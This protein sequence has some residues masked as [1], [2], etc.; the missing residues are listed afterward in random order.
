MMGSSADKARRCRNGFVHGQIMKYHRS[1]IAEANVVIG[2]A[3]KEESG[4]W[5]GAG[6]AQCRSR[7]NMP[8]K[9]PHRP[10]VCGQPLESSHGPQINV[11]MDPAVTT[12]TPRRAT[13]QGATLRRRQ[14]MA[15]GRAP[16]SSCAPTATRT[17]A[18]ATTSTTRGRTRPPRPPA[19][20]MPRFPSPRWCPREPQEPKE[21]ATPW[22]PRRDAH[23]NR[24]CHL[25][26]RLGI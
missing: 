20:T 3:P 17:K 8:L 9:K 6:P 22:Q 11:H 7:Q 5:R 24:R 16:S 25:R 1:G 12:V 21:D 2:G 26:V 18:P 10:N 15:N 13:L 23:A 14:P 19:S 4:V